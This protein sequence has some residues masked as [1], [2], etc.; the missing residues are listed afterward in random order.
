MA[1]RIVSQS[2]IE[3]GSASSRSRPRVTSEKNTITKIAPQVKR[4]DR[5]SIYINEKYAFS[6]HEYQLA[7]SGLHIGKELSK[8]EIDKFANE[9]QFDRPRDSSTS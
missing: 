8:S 6:L 7:G 1:L 2:D 3:A 9:S 4:S 5:Y